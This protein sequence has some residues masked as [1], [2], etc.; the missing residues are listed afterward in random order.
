VAAEL[1]PD[2]GYATHGRKDGTRPL[3]AGER[4]GGAISGGLTNITALLLNMQSICDEFLTVR[5]DLKTPLRGVFEWP[6]SPRKL[7]A[8]LTIT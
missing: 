7:A 8:T 4:V 2:L 1:S 3:P 5:P 6:E